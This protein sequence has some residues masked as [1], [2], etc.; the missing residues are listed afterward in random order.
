MK[1]V[2]IFIILAACV[3]PTLARIAS[4]KTIR[5]HAKARQGA[6]PRRLSAED[7]EADFNIS[8]K[9]DDLFTQYL[10]YHLQ[11]Q[12]DEN[13]SKHLVK[14]VKTLNEEVENFSL[15]MNDHISVVMNQM[16]TERLS[17]FIRT[18]PAGAGLD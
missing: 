8:E 5:E 1:V 15:Q 6:A 3:A 2:P 11:L 14:L 10:R 16:S 7:L 4:I 12:K 13:H 9:R 18:H 17:N